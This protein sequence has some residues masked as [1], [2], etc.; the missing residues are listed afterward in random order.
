[1]DAATA[2]GENLDLVRDAYRR[3]TVTIITLIDAQNQA[4]LSNLSANNAVYD[5]MVDFLAVERASA[6]FGF[7][8]SE[9]ERNDFVTRLE[10]F[11]AEQAAEGE[12]P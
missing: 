6:S 9:D 12:N 10:R 8:M 5:F 11:A 4:L 7:R 1:R 2:A 3:G